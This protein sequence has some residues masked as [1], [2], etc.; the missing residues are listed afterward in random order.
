MNNCIVQVL[1]DVR[2][3]RAEKMMLESYLQFY[4]DTEKEI[5]VSLLQQLLVIVDC[6]LLIIDEHEEFV[7]RR[8]LI[9]GLEMDCVVPQFRASMSRTIPSSKRSLMRY[10]ENALNKIS[11][12]T[13][14]RVAYIIPILKEEGCVVHDIETSIEGEA[15]HGE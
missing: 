4:E 1:Q 12:F 5:R 7:V 10:Q 6:W 15:K 3:Y 13:Y 9:D 8:N 11:A 14:A 2:K